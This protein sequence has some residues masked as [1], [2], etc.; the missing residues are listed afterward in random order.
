MVLLVLPVL[1][2]LTVNRQAGRLRS[3]PEGLLSLPIPCGLFSFYSVSLCA[4]E[5]NI[6]LGPDL[7][8]LRD[9]GDAGDLWRGLAS[10]L[11]LSGQKLSITWTC[12]LQLLGVVVCF[13]GGS[14]LGGWGRL[15]ESLSDVHPGSTG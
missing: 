15:S 11:S 9:V 13:P 12:Q 1:T 4:L 14:G 8:C 5:A 7:C 3:Q 6:S 2:F 10:E